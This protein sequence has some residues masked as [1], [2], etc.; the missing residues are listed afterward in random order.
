MD[1]PVNH[2]SIFEFDDF[3]A[4]RALLEAKGITTGNLVFGAATDLY[5]QVE[6]CPFVWTDTGADH[7]NNT[8]QTTMSSFGVNYRTFIK[9]S[10]N[11]Q[12]TEI[13]SL[14]RATGFG[15][16]DS[17]KMQG[18]I[19]PDA[20]ASVSVEDGYGKRSKL[21][22]P[23]FGIGYLDGRRRIMQPRSGVNEFGHPNTDG[24]DVSRM[25]WL[26]E[27]MVFMMDFDKMIH[28]YEE[29]HHS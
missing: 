12:L 17:M 13:S 2:G 25:D 23:N 27:F 10:Y 29:A 22:L 8:M 20:Y 14:T 26:S 7:Q 4:I 9:N 19:I 18:L 24:Y 28:V 21:T 11:V 16:I 15:A 1:L 5:S 3:D 6:N